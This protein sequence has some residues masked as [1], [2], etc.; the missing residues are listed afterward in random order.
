M[1][2]G[3]MTTM[4]LNTYSL[5]LRKR[6]AVMSICKMD[7]G[8]GSGGNDGGSRYM[9]NEIMPI[10]SVIGRRRKGCSTKEMISVLS[11]SGRAL[12]FISVL[13][14]LII[15]SHKEPLLEENMSAEGHPACFCKSF[16][17]H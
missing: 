11:P 5:P 15:L 12:F 3:K 1:P 14:W 17:A 2:S 7:G 6:A 4:A 9:S 8:G 16:N 10:Q 13:I